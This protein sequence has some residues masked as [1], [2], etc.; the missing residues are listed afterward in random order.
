M[1]YFIAQENSIGSISDPATCPAEDLIIF[2]TGSA[3][4]D[5]GD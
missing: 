2:R 1:H 4:F 3:T 5:E